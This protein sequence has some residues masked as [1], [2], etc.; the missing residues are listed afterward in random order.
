MA[1]TF[2]PEEIKVY[3]PDGLQF[4]DIW[5]LTCAQLGETVT[6]LLEIS[7]NATF[8]EGDLAGYH[9]IQYG[10]NQSVT[11]E[12]L[13]LLKTSLWDDWD[14][15]SN[16]KN[17]L[18]K[19]T[20]RETDGVVARRI[21]L[22]SYG[23]LR[24]LNLDHQ[25]GNYFDVVNETDHMKSEVY[26]LYPK[27]NTELEYKGRVSLSLGSVVIKNIMEDV[28]V[29]SDVMA[30]NTLDDLSKSRIVV[31]SSTSQGML[32]PIQAIRVI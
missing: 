6:K 16:L 25:I 24:R 10:V 9:H 28:S 21:R 26:S 8:A 19:I 14:K 17:A 13:V 22:G 5:G 3:G 11:Q 32:P 29:F 23:D 2:S 7:P 1:E 12:T 18:P 31:A 15:A 30:L 4:S 20:S 27:G